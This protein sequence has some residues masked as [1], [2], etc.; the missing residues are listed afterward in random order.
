MTFGELLRSARKQAGM[1]QREL[2]ALADVDHTYL[3]K[4]EHGHASPSASLTG[5]LARLLER[6]PMEFWQA[7]GNTPA[8]VLAMEADR[9]RKALQ[10]IIIA[11]DAADN[12][13]GI[14]PP[15]DA[16]WSLGW[17]MKDGSF[18]P[19]CRYTPWEVKALRA[20]LWEAGSGDHSGA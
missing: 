16:V 8:D 18:Y 10:R 11:F 19:V 3:S 15:P 17:W 20:E 12:L 1:S 5:Q 4:I 14:K 6:E 9:L 13:C 2:A 7:A